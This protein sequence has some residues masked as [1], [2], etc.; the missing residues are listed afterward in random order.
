MLTKKTIVGLC[1][2]SS[3]LGFPSKLIAEPSKIKSP[4]INELITFYSDL[5]NVDSEVIHKVIKCE[6][7][8]KVDA[9]NSIGENS[10]GI[11]QINLNAHRSI[12]VE[13]ATDPNFSIEFLAKNI[14][15]GKGKMWT[16]YRKL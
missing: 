14:S 5:Y 6:S 4:S 16:C 15:E 1:I 3:L 11:V 12:T 10:W 2:I 13:Q 9:H 8:Y 7:D